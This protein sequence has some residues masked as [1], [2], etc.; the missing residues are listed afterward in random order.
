D[1]THPPTFICLRTDIGDLSNAGS[2]ADLKGGMISGNG[3]GGAINFHTGGRSNRRLRLGFIYNN[4]LFFDGFEVHYSGLGNNGGSLG[5]ST[6]IA[7][8]PLVPATT[9]SLTVGSSSLP[10]GGGYF[11]GMTLGY[12]VI[13]GDYATASTD[14][15]IDCD[16]SLSLTVTLP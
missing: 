1:N 9:N 7:G 16:A 10:F 12:K 14:Y 15:T 5:N 2:N 13:T 6:L 11:G 4:G 3:Y 8:M